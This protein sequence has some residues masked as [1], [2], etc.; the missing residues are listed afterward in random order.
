VHHPLDVLHDL[1]RGKWRIEG[2]GRSRLRPLNPLLGVLLG[3]SSVHFFHSFHPHQDRPLTIHRQADILSLS[4][5]SPWLSPSLSRLIQFLGCDSN[6]LLSSEAERSSSLCSFL[7]GLNHRLFWRRSPIFSAAHAYSRTGSTRSRYFL[8][9]CRD[10]LHVS[11]RST[12]ASQTSQF[13]LFSAHFCLEIALFQ[14]QPEKTLLSPLHF[15]SAHFGLQ[16][17]DSSLSLI[18]TN[19]IFLTI[20]SLP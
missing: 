18:T 1:I 16:Y 4:S 14:F 9:A 15:D 7:C 10:Q 20:I 12:I 13:S 6:Q 11:F 5:R 17:F 3:R 8:C 2:Q 19:F